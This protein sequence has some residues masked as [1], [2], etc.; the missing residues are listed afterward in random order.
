MYL[1]ESLAEGP[2]LK[3]MTAQRNRTSIFPKL[4]STKFHSL[5]ANEY[6]GQPGYLFAFD[7]PD[8]LITSCVQEDLYRRKIDN[9]SVIMGRC[10]GA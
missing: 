4:D 6:R 3:R 7:V 8:M 9:L 10:V 2:L 5:L 1:P